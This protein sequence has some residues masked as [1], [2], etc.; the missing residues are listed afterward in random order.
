M[1]KSGLKV[2]IAQHRWWFP[3]VVS[4][5]DLANH[6]FARKLIKRG[7]QVRVHGIAPPGLSTRMQSRQY[8]ARGVPVCLVKSDFLQRLRDEIRTFKPDVVF[9]SCPEPNCGQDDMTRM[10]DVITSFDIPVVLYVHDIEGTLPLFAE[11]KNQLAKVVTN[12]RF[13]AKRIAEL[14][15]RDAEVVYPVPDLKKYDKSSSTGRFITFF[16]PSHFKG[17]KIANTLATERFKER[18]FLFVE[19]FIDPDGHGIFLSRSGNLVHARRSPDVATIYVMTQTVIIPS[20]W[21]EPFGRIAVE[22]MHTGIPVI[23]SRTGGLEE[24]VGEGGLLVDDFTNVDAWASAIERLDDP[25]ERKQVVKAG[26]QHVKQFSL[27]RE[28][29]KLIEI[30]EQ[31][32]A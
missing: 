7:V 26:K 3:S 17:L 22:A 29:D 25:K 18:P 30:L 5:A 20:Q 9:T 16:N 6:E 2:L 10:V 8:F 23:A 11:A 31:V 1:K 12:S 19:G 14:W 32:S 13:M 28:V 15:S 27:S 21:E 4:G 24:S